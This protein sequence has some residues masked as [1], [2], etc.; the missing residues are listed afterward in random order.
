MAKEKVFVSF[1]FENDKNYRYILDELCKNEEF[2]FIF[3]DKGIKKVNE[4]DIEPIQQNLIKKIEESTYTLVIIGKNSNTINKNKKFIG[5]RNWINYEINKSESSGNKLV[6]V[7]LN[8]LYTSPPEL[9][10]SEVVWADDATVDSILEAL[11]K[12]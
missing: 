11:N 1:D 8:S 7:K 9:F 2:E 6:A 10:K 4:W 3:E 5:M 12:A